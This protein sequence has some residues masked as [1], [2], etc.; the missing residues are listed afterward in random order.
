ME[1]V[2][3]EIGV[4]ELVEEE[5]EEVEEEAV[6][7]EAVEELVFVWQ[8]AIEKID[9]KDTTLRINFFFMNQTSFNSLFLHEDRL[10]DGK[11]HPEYHL[12]A[13]DTYAC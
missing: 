13:S 1:R 12:T 9:I 2:V 7:S 8:A 6:E 5:E 3:R 11:H 10:T 4:E